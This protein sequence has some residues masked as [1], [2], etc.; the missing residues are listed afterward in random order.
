MT[1]S[2]KQLKVINDA[3]W[4]MG[5][6]DNMTW[7]PYRKEIYHLEKEYERRHRNYTRPHGGMNMSQAAKYFT[8]KHIFDGLRMLKAGKQY[9][10]KDYLAVK[11][12]VFYAHSVAAVYEKEIIEAFDGFDWEAFASL[13]YADMMA[14]KEAS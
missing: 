11:K 2:R 9:S 10:I 3:W 4:R 13:D 1:I 8:A 5:I 12:S 14:E 7:T 6:L